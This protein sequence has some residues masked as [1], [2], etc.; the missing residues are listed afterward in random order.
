MSNNYIFSNAEEELLSLPKEYTVEIALENNDLLYT[1]LAQSFNIDQ[2]VKFLCNFNNGI[3]D[4]IRI[5]MFGID[6]PPTLSIL[7]YNGEYLKLTI[8]VSRYDG[9]VYD[10]FIISYGYDIIIDKT[11]YNSYNAYSFFLNKFDNGLA[12]IFTYTIFNMQL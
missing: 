6:G 9:D 12:L 3:P 11:Y 4:K 8:D 10:E 7:E 2:L 1:P 5:T